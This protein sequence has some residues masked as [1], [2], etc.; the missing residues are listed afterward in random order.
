[1]LKNI[2]IKFLKHNGVIGSSIVMINCLEKKIESL[3]Y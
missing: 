2:N 1:M 3:S